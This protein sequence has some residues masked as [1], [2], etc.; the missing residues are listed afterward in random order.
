MNTVM[1]CI[2]GYGIGKEG[3]ELSHLH[4][5]VITGIVLLTGKLDSMLDQT[6]T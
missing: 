6:T 2:K 3:K 1:A 4:L 5:F